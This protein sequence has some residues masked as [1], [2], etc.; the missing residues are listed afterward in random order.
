MDLFDRNDKTLIFIKITKDFVEY[1]KDAVIK[2][3]YSFINDKHL[4]IVNDTENT[5]Y[6]VTLI[7]SLCKENNVT[8]SLSTTKHALF[9]RIK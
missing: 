5:P 8:F 1:F 7:D 3:N 4:L 2:T 6:Y 9:F